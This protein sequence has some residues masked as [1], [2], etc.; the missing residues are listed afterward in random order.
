MR[1]YINT[2]LREEAEFAKNYRDSID[3]LFKDVALSKMPGN[4]FAGRKY[5]ILLIDFLSFRTAIKKLKA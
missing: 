1:S 2:R 3:G 4:N 5:F